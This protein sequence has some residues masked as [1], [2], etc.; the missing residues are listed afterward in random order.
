[1]VVEDQWRQPANIWLGR[2]LQEGLG[3]C[4]C[5]CVC[6]CHRGTG[7]IGI[8]QGREAAVAVIQDNPRLVCRRAS[9]LGLTVH[10]GVEVHL[11]VPVA[12][13]RVLRTRAF[14]KGE[15]AS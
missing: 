6:V 8:G 2:I 13:N 12:N 15:P 14:A 9:R 4:V 3:Q 7:K 5:V 1:M 10:I 11:G